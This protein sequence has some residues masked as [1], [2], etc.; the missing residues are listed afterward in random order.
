VQVTT[1][2]QNDTFIQI[3]SGLKGGEEVVSAPYSAISK[4]LKDNDIVDKVD[5]AKL[6]NTEEKKGGE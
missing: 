6:F 4:T 3:L 1:G 2:I 5:K